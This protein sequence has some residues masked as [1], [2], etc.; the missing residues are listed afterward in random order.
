[1]PLSAAE[2]QRRYRERLRLDPALYSTY[3]E[4]ERIRWQERK[5]S[6]KLKQIDELTEREQRRK[7]RTWKEQQRKCRE[8]HKAAAEILSPPHTPVEMFHESRQLKQSKT[9]RSK[10]VAKLRYCLKKTQKDLC[11]SQRQTSK[12]KK[13]WQRAVEQHKGN[14]PETPRTK[15]RRLLQYAGPSLVRKTLI[16]HH[17]IIDQIRTRYKETA[18][19][20][21]KCM[22][23]R[24]LCGNILKKY[25]LQRVAEQSIGFSAKRWKTDSRMSSIIGTS[26]KKYHSLAARCK[27]NVVNFFERDDVSRIMAG[28]KQTVTQKKVKKQ[29][30]LLNDTLSNLYEKFRAEYEELKLSFSVFCRLKPFWVMKPSMADRET[31]L[32]KLHENTQFLAQKMK[33]VQAIVTD[34]LEQLVTEIVCDAN[35]KECMYSECS[36]CKDMAVKVKVSDPNLECHWNQWKTVKEKREMKRSGKTEEKEVTMTVKGTETGSIGDM[37]DQFHSQNDKV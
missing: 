26:K 21:Q 6:G 13:R 3:L 17:A 24:L 29:K 1:M 31:C 33:D 19:E 14:V 12:F 30:R 32:C 16:F 35:R 27:L 4:K 15:T 36:E 20:R 28:K 7:R 5:E 2:K 23:S 8:K 37:V 9:K 22:F 34:N 25:R 10:T 11:R 18:Q